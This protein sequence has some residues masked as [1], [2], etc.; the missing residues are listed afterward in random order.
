MQHLNKLSFVCAVAFLWLFH[1]PPPLAATEL[2][3]ASVK[4]NVSNQASGPVRMTDNFFIIYDPSTTMDVPYKDT[5]LSRIEAQ[6]Q[7]LQRSNAS[8]PELGWQ[9]GLYPHW[10]GGLWLHGSPMAF[11]PYYPLHRYENV[12]FGE[13]INQ[14]PTLPQAPPMLQ[15]G[16]MKLEHMLG[17]PG[18]TDVFI[19]S[20]GKDSTYP[21]LEPPPLEQAKKLAETFEVCF[22]I[23]SSATDAAGK[24]LL[25]DIGS[26][27]SCSQVMD[28]DTVYN[29]PE[30]L[31]GK[32]YMDTDNSQFNNIL[33]DFDK[34]EIKPLY[35]Q[36]L[37]TLGQFLIEH[38]Q[39]YVV[40]SGFTDNI[41]SEVY[42]IDLSQ[43]RAQKV[44]QYLMRQHQVE[45]KRILLYWYGDTN[46]AT[47]N[48]TAQGRQLNRR[49]TINLRNQQ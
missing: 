18:R 32:L 19:F 31:F 5:G 29:N 47:D 6:K 10:K 12:P 46:P 37:D 15:T 4:P 49:V 30:H 38:P 1:C 35:T 9:A 44:Q 45:Q 34:T 42:N 2:Q 21:E 14:L 17:L 3:T 36:P 24:Q 43:Q 20:D 48:D 8:L 40:L 23:I 13:A 28:F 26:V 33:F 39:T 16:L 7:I 27:N 25:H 41:G 22:T 11:K